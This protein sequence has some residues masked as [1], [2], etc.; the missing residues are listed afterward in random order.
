MPEYIERE[1]LIADIEKHHCGPC[2]AEGNDYK[3]VAC[4]AC[5]VD[6]MILVIDA[7]PAISAVP[8]VHGWWELERAGKH[9]QI[10]YYSCSI[11]GFDLPYNP[12]Y[13]PEYCEH[14]GAK[15]DGGDGHVPEPPEVEQK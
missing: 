12:E 5:W 10:E 3:G 8:V 2:K 11:C 14:C 15:M 6:D 1:A 9:K 7:A 4:R 13:L